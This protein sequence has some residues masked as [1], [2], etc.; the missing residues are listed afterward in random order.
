MLLN[1][2]SKP[3]ERRSGRTVLTIIVQNVAAMLRAGVKGFEMRGLSENEAR[4]WTGN[5]ALFK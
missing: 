1:P 5:R 3:H 2:R 4:A